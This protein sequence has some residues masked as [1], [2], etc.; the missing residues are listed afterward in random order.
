MSSLVKLVVFVPISDADKLRKA[1]GD[2]GAGIIGNYTHC[3]FSHRGFGRF[4]P[5]E[6]ANPTIGQ[7]GQF[8]QVEE[9]RIETLCERSKLKAVI[10]AMKEVHPYEEVAFDIIPLLS[11][12]EI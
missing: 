5:N 4:L 3:S 6:N 10:K 11:E 12:S 7:P 8:E 9:E 2:S 1:L